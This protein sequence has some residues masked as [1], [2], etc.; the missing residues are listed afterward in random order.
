[1]IRRAAENISAAGV[2]AD[3]AVMDCQNIQYHDESFDLVVCRDLTWTLADPVKAYKEWT[4][5]LRKGGVLLVFDAC[6]YLHLFDEKRMKVFEE[7]NNNLRKNMDMVY[8]TDI[9]IQK[10]AMNFLKSYL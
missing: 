2:K 4:R 6:W 3:L 7:Y 9:K 10:N 1:M 5:V 8:L